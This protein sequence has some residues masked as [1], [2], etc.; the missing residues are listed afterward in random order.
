M[1]SYH[2]NKGRLQFCCNT[3]FVFL[4]LTVQCEIM[5]WVPVASDLPH[6]PVMAEKSLD[7]SMSP[8]GQNWS[9]LEMT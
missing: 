2:R 4:R 5:H 9:D 8:G 6:P 1:R 3:S 7:M